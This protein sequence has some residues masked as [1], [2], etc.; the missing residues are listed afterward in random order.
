[1]PEKATKGS[2]SYISNDGENFVVLGDDVDA[3]STAEGN[4]TANIVT[5]AG[6]GTSPTSYPGVNEG[7]QPRSALQEQGFTITGEEP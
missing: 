6:D 4:Q 1:M 3:A 5:L 7:V 2:L